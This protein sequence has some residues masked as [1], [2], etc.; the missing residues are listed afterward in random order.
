[1]LRKRAHVDRLQRTN[2]AYVDH[3]SINTKQMFTHGVRIHIMY[4]TCHRTFMLQKINYFQHCSRVLPQSLQ[5]A[6]FAQ[7]WRDEEHGRQLPRDSRPWLCCAGPS[8]VCYRT[9]LIV[10]SNKNRGTTPLSLFVRWPLWHRIKELTPW[11]NNQRL[12]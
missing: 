3:R 10:H 8:L 6:V 11:R 12:A 9:A 7:V 4:S 5:E 1:M 2:I